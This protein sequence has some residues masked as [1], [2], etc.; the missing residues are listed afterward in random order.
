MGRAVG[1]K[2]RVSTLRTVMLLRYVQ[3]HAATKAEDVH[4]AEANWMPFF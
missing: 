2:G 3:V 1:G 4:P